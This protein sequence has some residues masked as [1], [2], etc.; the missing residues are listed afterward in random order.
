ML[1]TRI[2]KV[3]K[4]I[5]SIRNKN[6]AQS[7]AIVFIKPV[8]LI[9]FSRFSSSSE[10]N[11]NQT[12]QQTKSIRAST[13]DYDDADD[14]VEPPKSAFGKVFQSLNIAHIFIYNFIIHNLVSHWRNHLTATSLRWWSFI[15]YVY[16]V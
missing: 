15:L 2:S 11:S 16:C 8:N 3:T 13:Y 6:L 4:S 14:Y 9:S 5:C 12:S 7:L 1:S 10:N